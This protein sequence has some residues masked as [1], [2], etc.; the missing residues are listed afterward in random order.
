MGISPKTKLDQPLKHYLGNLQ[1]YQQKKNNKDP[2]N[3]CNIPYY[4]KVHKNNQ[5]T[6]N[7]TPIGGFVNMASTSNLLEV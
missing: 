1:T 5:L 7:S 3:R 2:T 6:E 4:R